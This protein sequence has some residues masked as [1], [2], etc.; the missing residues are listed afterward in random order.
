MDRISV[1]LEPLVWADPWLKAC[2]VMKLE[3]EVDTKK[4]EVQIKAETY[5]PVCCQ[6]SSV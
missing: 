4:K 5:S 3:T 1:A 2:R 6:A